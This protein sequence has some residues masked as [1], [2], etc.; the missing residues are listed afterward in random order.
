MPR[1]TPR[2]RTPQWVG[3]EGVQ[4]VVILSIDDMN[5]T[6]HWENYLRPILERLE[7][8]DGRAPV[9][10][11]TTQIDTQDPH[12]LSFAICHWAGTSI[13]ICPVRCRPIQ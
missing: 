1:L 4:A 8:I 9:S 3:E 5:Q 7:A 12:M 13:R 2:S 10:I 6:G 11:M